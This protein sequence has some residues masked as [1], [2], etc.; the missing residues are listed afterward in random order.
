MVK[1]WMLEYVNT[2]VIRLQN[3][4]SYSTICTPSIQLRPQVIMSSHVATV[5]IMLP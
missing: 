1:K 4:I 5:A 2:V 3:E